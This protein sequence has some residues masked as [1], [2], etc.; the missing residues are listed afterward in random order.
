MA[1][2]QADNVDRLGPPIP[3][4]PV[5]LS[6]P[7]A[8]RDYPEALLAQARFGREML[9]RFEDRLVDQLVTPLARRGHAVFIARQARAWIDL[10]RD[11]REI[12][13]EMVAPRPEASHVRFTPRVIGGLGLV[14][15]RLSGLG[16]IYRRPLDARDIRDRI[17]RSYRP[18]HAALESA[19]TA[20]RNRFGI[21][22]LLDCHS[23]PPLSESRAASVV[24]GDHDGRSAGA[25]FVE[26]ASRLFRESGLNVAHNAPYAGGHIIARHG[27]KGGGA[28]ALQIELCRSLYLDVSLK[29][30]GERF[31][32]ISGMLGRV[33]DAL[34][35][36]ALDGDELLAAE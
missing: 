34:A 33:A 11:E 12:D 9:A 20:A 5:I 29:R 14:P 22:V 28:H 24:I 21:A 23:M 3:D 13:P 30:R 8:G 18:F 35:E 36:R 1:H 27:L 19:V 26:T 6:V 15:R 25:R 31:D 2:G 7:H 32:W 17:E 4:T 16:E 10:N